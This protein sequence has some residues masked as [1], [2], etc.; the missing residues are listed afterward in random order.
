M[1][2][3]SVNELSTLNWSFEED[4]IHYHRAGYS[5]IGIL[6]SKLIEYGEEKGRELLKEHSM[7]PSSL[8]YFGGF[9]GESGNTFRRSM[10]EALDVIQLAADMGIETVVIHPGARNGHTRNHA[11]RLLRTAFAVLSEASQAVNVQLA[12]EPIHCGCGPDYFLNTIPQCL[13]IIGQI[14]NPNLGMVFDSYHLAQE[15]DALL[16]LDSIVSHVRL[17]QL[18]DA[19]YAPMGRSNRCPL[20]D[21]RIPLLELINQFATAGYTG[22]YEIELQG[23]TSELHYEHLL[24]TTR[25]TA[26]LWESNLIFS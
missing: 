3:L 24:A 13:E 11:L 6:H 1:L 25:K 10:L 18:G 9:T 15:S 20:G 4:V 22:F 16:W 2:Q 26:K 17:V 23:T 12:M 21:G 19:K 7:T 14:G 5:A 8:T